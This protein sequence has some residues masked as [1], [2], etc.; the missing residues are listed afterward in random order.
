M[1]R[2]RIIHSVVAFRAAAVAALLLAFSPALRAD[3]VSKSGTS[4]KTSEQLSEQQISERW[5][6]DGWPLLKT[7]C[8]D[9]HSDDVQEGELNLAPLQDFASLESSAASMQ[10]VLEMVQFGAMPPE[11]ADQPSDQDRKRLVTL[12]DRAMFAVT[13]DLRPRPGKVTARRL[14]R[15]EYNHA[16]RDLFAMDLRPADAF[17]S[18]EVGAGFDNNGDVLSL[19]PML[20][21]KYLDAAESVA[22]QVVIDPDSLP[23]IDDSRAS[24]Q[25][26]VHGD[27]QTG[28]FNGRFLA[29]DSVAWADFEIPVDGEYDVRISG[30]NT[31]PQGPPTQVAVY[32]IG[33][34]LRGRGELAYYG[35]GGSSQ[36]FKFQVSL[37]AG[38]QRF[39]VEPI[40]ENRELNPGKTRSDELAELSPEV[41]G[42]AVERL[43]EPLK[44]D[45][46]IDGEVY[47][48]MVRRISVEGPTKR[49]DD[50]F[51][52]SQGKI[53]RKRAKRERGRWREVEP[54]ARECLRPLIRR[55]FRQDVSD[56]EIEPYVDLVKQTTDRGESYY[57]GLQVAISAVL[58]SPRFLFRVESPPEGWEAGEDGSV[59]LTPNQLATRLSFFLWSSL[60]DEQLLDDASQ[61]KLDAESLQRHVDRMLSDS[62]A[63]SLGEQFA[64]QWLGLRNLDSHEADTDRFD[65]FTPSLRQAMV[66][67]TQTL[68]LYLL[69]KNRPVTE[70]L[71]CDYTFAN[72]ELAKHYGIS[73]VRGDELRLVSLKG[74]PRRG[75]LS[76]A[77][78]LTLTSNPGRTSPVKRGKWILEN[79]L[80]TPPPEPPSGVPE[81]EETKTADADATLREQ[82]E[83]HRSNPSCASCH[84]VMD[85]LGF[86]LEQYDAIGRFRTMDGKATIDASGELPGS[87]SF[88]G[89]AE[90]CQILGKTEAEAFARTAVERLLTFA[91]GRELTPDDRCTVDAIVD[92]TAGHGHR[93]QD[94]ILEVVRSRPFRYYEWTQIP[95]A[96]VDPS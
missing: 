24:D 87:R 52:P 61:G 53:V 43:Q 58:V 89:A 19:S 79:V 42:A 95:H 71:T 65:S 60:P 51:P 7:F 76:H 62:K 70:L 57:R 73:G 35:G 6:S 31:E 80:G 54:A 28:R 44:P 66:S 41:I 11:D 4:E 38:K 69:R 37:T 86:G 82:M 67:E 45:R 22:T 13:C 55:A 9:C 59:A 21:E 26:L 78:I 48:F 81:L 27:A 36:S 8:L 68:F 64:A 94:L 1:T 96:N 49:S 92:A 77:S 91:I 33:G 23:S 72:E 12:L 29:A 74:S 50:S 14:N 34:M 17:P 83:I 46:R 47:P 15:A 30:G 75:V 63:V 90:L 3:E 88:D 20:I 84:R 10:R 18:D 2:F 56:E 32:D 39:Y 25:L 93:L 40:E 16:I 85:E 5:S